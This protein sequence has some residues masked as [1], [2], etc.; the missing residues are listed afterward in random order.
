MFKIHKISGLL[1]QNFDI[2]IVNGCRLRPCWEYRVVGGLGIPL[3]LFVQ[4]LFRG[5][6]SIL[7]WPAYVCD[8]AALDVKKKKIIPC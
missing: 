1:L 3:H 5:G 4:V 8:P 6:G 7:R 2:F